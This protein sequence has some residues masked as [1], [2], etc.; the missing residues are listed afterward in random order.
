MEFGFNFTVFREG[1]LLAT[2]PVKLVPH[3][4]RRLNA[5]FSVFFPPQSRFVPLPFWLLLLFCT[6]V[7][8]IISLAV[9]QQ[10]S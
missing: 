3:V 10:T 8:F 4:L 9:G 5:H 1:F 2:V 7:S 6:H